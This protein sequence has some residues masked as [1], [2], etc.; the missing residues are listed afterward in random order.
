MSDSTLLGMLDVAHNLAMRGARNIRFSADPTNHFAGMLYFEI[1]EFAGSLILLR[2][3][4]RVAGVSV[5]MRTALDAFVDL[6]IC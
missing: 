2:Q 1:I 3:N 5:I 6:K 4:S